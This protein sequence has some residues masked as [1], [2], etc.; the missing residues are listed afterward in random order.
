MSLHTETVFY[1]YGY[2]LVLSLMSPL[3]PGVAGVGGGRIYF[4]WCIT[5][6]QHLFATLSPEEE[7]TLFLNDLEEEFT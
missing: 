5:I 3:I 4:D 2:T 1:N 7:A 6:R